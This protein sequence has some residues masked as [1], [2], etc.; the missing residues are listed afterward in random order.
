MHPVPIL[1]VFWN[2]GRSMGAMIHTSGMIRCPF[3]VPPELK[4]AEFPRDGNSPWLT[5]GMPLQSA[6]FSV[7]D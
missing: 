3:A 2:T 6:T 7:G 4:P 5:G 1:P